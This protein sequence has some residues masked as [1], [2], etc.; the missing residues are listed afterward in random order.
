MKNVRSLNERMGGETNALTSRR[1]FSQRIDPTAPLSSNYETVWGKIKPLEGS[2]S[3]R[4]ILTLTERFCLSGVPIGMSVW[5]EKTG[6]TKG[7]GKRTRGDENILNWR[8]DPPSGR[9]REKQ[10]S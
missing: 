8:K 5:R 2:L 1:V 3:F 4:L 6:Q 9:A 10:G 7:F